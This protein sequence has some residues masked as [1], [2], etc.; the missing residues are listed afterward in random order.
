MFGELYPQNPRFLLAPGSDDM[1]TLFG[2][3]R[4]MSGSV[5]PEPGGVLEQAAIMISAFEIMAGAAEEFKEGE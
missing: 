4:R 3:Y 1:M 5:L 2:F